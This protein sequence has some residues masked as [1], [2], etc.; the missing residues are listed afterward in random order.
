MSWSLAIVKRHYSC[1]SWLSNHLLKPKISTDLVPNKP[2]DLELQPSY[3]HDDILKLSRSGKIQELSNIL[4]LHYNSFNNTTVYWATIISTAW[5]R[6]KS[7]EKWTRIH[8][9]WIDLKNRD[10]INAVVLASYLDFCGFYGSLDY[11]QDAWEFVNQ[12]KRW[13]ICSNHYNSYIQALIKLGAK[14]DALS[15]LKAMPRHHITCKTLVTL[16]GPLRIKGSDKEILGECWEWIEM[17]GLLGIRDKQESEFS[18]RWRKLVK[19]HHQKRFQ[20]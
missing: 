20:T 16:V 1:P 14:E 7:P 19:E 4:H 12:S 11:L 9:I 6:S 3:D 15:T 5:A 8:S 13:M 2:M 18:R 17:K 10:E